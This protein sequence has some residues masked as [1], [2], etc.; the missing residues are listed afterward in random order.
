M[1]ITYCI[2]TMMC[3]YTQMGGTFPKYVNIL[4]LC[5]VSTINT[6]PGV[7]HYDA[8]L[9]DYTDFGWTIFGDFTAVDVNAN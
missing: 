4:L 3:I 8:G 2:Q 5:P 7:L 1:P 6:L 9:H